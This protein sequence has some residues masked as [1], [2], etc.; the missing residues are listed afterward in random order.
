MIGCLFLIASTIGESPGSQP[1]WEKNEMGE[2]AI[3]AMRSAPYPHPSREQG[4]KGRE[5][6]FPRDPHYIDSSVVVFIP[7]TFR[8]GPRVDVLVYLHGH[9]NNIRRALDQYRL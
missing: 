4:V 7:R 6:F 2:T 1:S 3:V 8:P 9:L 5:K